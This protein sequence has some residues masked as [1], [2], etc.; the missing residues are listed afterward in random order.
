MKVIITGVAGFIGSN[1]ALKTLELGYDIV[2]IDNFDPYYDVSLKRKNLEN[3]LSFKNFKFYEVDILDKET[4]RK[5]ILEEEPEVVVHLAARPGVRASIL[6]PFKY[7]EINIKGTLTLLECIKDKKIKLIF[8]SSSSVYGD[9]RGKFSESDKNIVPVSPYGYSKRAAEILCETYNKLYGI[10]V[11][12]LRLFTVY[13]PSQR[14]DMAIHLFT[15]KILKGEEIRVFGEGKTERD[16]TYID[17]IVKGI[18]S[19]IQLKDFDFDIINL[20]NSKP[21]SI[22]KVIKIIERLLGKKAKIVLEPLPMGDVKRTY[23]NIEKAKMILNYNP[24]TS[25]EDGI[26]SF[27]KWHQKNCNC[28]EGI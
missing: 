21:V 8:S 9:K 1:L 6:D 27:L 2:G 22:F 14:P 18:I 5:V 16:Y 17:D 23:A 4:I 20:G 28:H 15:K 7:I 11:L 13:G 24:V 19:A 25:L 3:I 10:K 12:V 26:E